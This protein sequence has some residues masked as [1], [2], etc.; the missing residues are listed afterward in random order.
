MTLAKCLTLAG[1]VLD[2][3][4]VLVIGLRAQHWMQQFWKDAPPIFDT[5]LHKLVYYGAWWAIAIGFGLQALGV[6]FGN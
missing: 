2:I 4:G 3:V 6:L 5:G 1:L